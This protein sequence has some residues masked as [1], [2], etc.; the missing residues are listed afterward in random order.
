MIT[1]P[2]RELRNE[3]MDSYSLQA[4]AMQ[5]TGD[6]SD[7]RARTR[8]KLPPVRLLQTA[9]RSRNLSYF[10]VLAPTPSIWN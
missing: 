10:F 4:S 5:A 9:G 3:D 2:E 6:G 8:R 7:S 1:A